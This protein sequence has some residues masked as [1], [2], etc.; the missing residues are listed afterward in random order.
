[1][2]PNKLDACKEQHKRELEQQHMQE[3]EDFQ[4]QHNSLQDHGKKELK[5]CEQRQ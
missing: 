5:A 2:M 4:Q 3:V 1:M